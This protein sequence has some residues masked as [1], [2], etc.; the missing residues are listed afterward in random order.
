MKRW[1]IERN[2]PMDHSRTSRISVT[3]ELQQWPK[4]VTTGRILLQEHD[5]TNKQRIF[6][7]KFYSMQLFDCLYKYHQKCKYSSWPKQIPNRNC[8]LMI[9]AGTSIKS[10]ILDCAIHLLVEAENGG[11]QTKSC[12]SPP[13]TSSKWW[14]RSYWIILPPNSCSKNVKENA[15]SSSNRMAK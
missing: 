11:T 13:Y 10:F 15:K 12:S 3:F 8:S 9:C 2:V 6:F 7:F 4:P 5:K 14:G 1:G